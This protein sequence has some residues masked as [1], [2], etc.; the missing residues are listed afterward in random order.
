MLGSV[1]GTPILLEIAIFE[2]THVQDLCVNMVQALRRAGRMGTRVF[3]NAVWSFVVGPLKA[4][5]G[6]PVS[7]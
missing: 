5:P 2:T 3:F 7:E 1:L 4:E 6:R